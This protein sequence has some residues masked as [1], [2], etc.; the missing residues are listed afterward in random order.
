MNPPALGWSHPI[1]SSCSSLGRITVDAN[2]TSLV[3]GRDYT[4]LHFHPLLCSQSSITL[5]LAW[6]GSIPPATYSCNGMLPC[7]T[8]RQKETL[9]PFLTFHRTPLFNSSA[10]HNTPLQIWDALL[11][12]CTC[13]P[14]CFFTPYF[15][16]T[17]SRQACPPL[18]SSLQASF[19]FITQLISFDDFEFAPP[20]F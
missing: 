8:S 18:V 19:A 2:M 1:T 10:P 6:S 5:L 17:T 20:V 11:L 15:L 7:Q 12:A 16:F 9:F 3:G 4:S 13:T 14:S